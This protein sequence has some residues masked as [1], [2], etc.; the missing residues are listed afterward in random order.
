MY[1][2]FEVLHRHNGSEFH[3]EALRR[4]LNVTVS[5]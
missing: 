1:S 4:S 3:S 2:I 5:G